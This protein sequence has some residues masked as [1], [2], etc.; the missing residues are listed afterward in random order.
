M[1]V[2]NLEDL[3]IEQVRDL[4]NAETQVQKTYERW[5]NAAQ[6]QQL[7]TLLSDRIE[8]ASRRMNRLQ[9][10]CNAMNVEPTGEKCHGMEG[11]LKEGTEYIQESEPTAVRDAGLI[12]D[13]QRVEHYGIAGYGCAHTYAERLGMDEAAQALENNLDESS[14]IDQRMTNLAKGLLNPKAEP[15]TA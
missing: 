13:A 1:T 5:S 8:Q 6:S 10:I 9:Q 11:L 3:F 4:Y 7:K 15:S 2:A 14:E 12:A